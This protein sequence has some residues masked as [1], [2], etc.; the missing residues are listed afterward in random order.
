[1]TF[2]LYAKI[3]KRLREIFGLL[4]FLRLS[5]VFQAEAQPN[6]CALGDIQHC[7]KLLERVENLYAIP[8]QLLKAIALTESGRMEGDHFVPWP[9]TINVK[10]KGYFYRTKA[11]A[12]RAVQKF[13][14]QGIRSID[15]GCMQINLMHHPHAFSSL[16]E[17]FDPAANIRYWAEFLVRHRDSNKGLWKHAVGLYHSGRPTLYESYRQ[18]MFKIWYENRKKKHRFNPTPYKSLLLGNLLK[19]SICRMM[20]KIS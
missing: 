8:S 17:A 13:Q 4:G 3:F 9:W 14:K 2:N 1:M 5:I 16:E 7:L 12:I 15:V 19:D 6:S 10:R 18:K 20:K 11:D